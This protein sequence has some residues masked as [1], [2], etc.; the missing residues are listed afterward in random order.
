M[1]V[2]RGDKIYDN[3]STKEL[4]YY[5]MGMWEIE[6]NLPLACI[7]RYV[8]YLN[9]WDQ[10]T[11]KY[12]NLMDDFEYI[13]NDDQLEGW[14][15]HMDAVLDYGEKVF[16]PLE[17]NVRQVLAELVGIYQTLRNTDAYREAERHVTKAI[18]DMLENCLYTFFVQYENVNYDKMVQDIERLNKDR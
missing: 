18:R 11:S 14:S 6:S 4:D 13:M 12:S 16:C 2:A 15:K 9:F 1:I 3:E 8:G 17:E 7:E 10:F 5:D